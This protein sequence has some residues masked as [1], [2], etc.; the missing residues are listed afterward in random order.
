MMSS[1][2]INTLYTIM[3]TKR[4]ERTH[5]F[6]SLLFQK[7][8]NKLFTL[9]QNLFSILLLSRVDFAKADQRLHCLHV[10]S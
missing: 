5:Y 2:F 1:N 3:K 6:S 10:Q 4:E 7:G 8:S 9:I